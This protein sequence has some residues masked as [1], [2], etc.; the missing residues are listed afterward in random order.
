MFGAKA[1]DEGR[2]A[3][4]GVVEN[5]VVEA[6]LGESVTLKRPFAQINFLTDDIADA[7][8]NELIIGENTH[9]SIILSK[10]ATLLTTR[11]L[12]LRGMN[13]KCLIKR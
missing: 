5:K 10:V 2:D 9:S 1:N 6:S 12:C 11:L 13:I 3:F 8:K 4:L 7:G